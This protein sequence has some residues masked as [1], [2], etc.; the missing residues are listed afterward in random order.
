[1][2]PLLKNNRLKYFGGVCTMILGWNSGGFSGGAST[3][4][5]VALELLKNSLR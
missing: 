5:N 1:M 2:N 3:N 4:Y